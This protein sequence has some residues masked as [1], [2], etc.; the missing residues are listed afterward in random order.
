ML[1]PITLPTA[2]SVLPARVA[3][4]LTVICGALLPKATMLKPMI[5]G[6]TLRLAA[7]RTAA[8]TRISA[9][10]IS[11]TKPLINSSRLKGERAVS[12]KMARAPV[13]CSALA[14]EP[15]RFRCPAY[16]AVRQPCV[17]HQSGG[18]EYAG[19]DH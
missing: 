6:R 5:S 3:C 13:S 7:R 16:R 12:P 17:K 19:R 1:L 15:V 18:H 8:R 2:M 9:P 10:I 14:R 11:N 4:K